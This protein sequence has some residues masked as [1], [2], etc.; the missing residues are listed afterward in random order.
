VYVVGMYFGHMRI[1]DDDKREVSEGLDAI[2]ES[3]RQDGEREVGGREQL[4]RCERGSS[5]S[6][7]CDRV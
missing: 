5:V 4:L 3:R 2:R 1:R 6:E 7:P